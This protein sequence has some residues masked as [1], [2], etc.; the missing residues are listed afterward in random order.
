MVTKAKA[1]QVLGMP[2]TMASAR[3]KKQLMFHL[4]KKLGMDIC[5]RCQNPIE[6]VVEFSVEHKESWLLSD[7]P[8]ET[9]FD[10]DNIAFSHLKCNIGAATRL[11]K[12]YPN[13]LKRKAAAFQRYKNSPEQYAKILEQKKEA[14]YRDKNNPEKYARILERARIGYHRRKNNE[15]E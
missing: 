6:T 2:E 10:L 1:L 9:F 5:Y 14:Y 7:N 3:L 12:Q 13:E 15:P 11:N 4:A 8:Y